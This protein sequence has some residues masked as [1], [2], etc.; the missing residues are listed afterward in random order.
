[1][2]LQDCML[3]CGIAINMS[4]IAKIN[5]YGPNALNDTKFLKGLLKRYEPQVSSN[6]IIC[7]YL[8]NSDV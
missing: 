8:F 4:I 1:M 2:V 5:R 3:I 7:I 6:F